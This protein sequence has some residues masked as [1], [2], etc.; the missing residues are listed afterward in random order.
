M[1]RANQ[2]LVEVQSLAS[3]LD[4]RSPA[5]TAIPAIIKALSSVQREDENSLIVGNDCFSVQS[6]RGIAQQ[7]WL[8]M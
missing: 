5:M 1:Y 3:R 4:H 8:S 6:S 7:D 2:P